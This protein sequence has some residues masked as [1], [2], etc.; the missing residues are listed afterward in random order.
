MKILIIGFGLSGKSLYNYLKNKNDEIFIYDENIELENSYNYKR[1]LNDLPLFD[2]GI[3]SPGIKK[4][5]KEYRLI[6]T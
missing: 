6:L 4:D 2:L 1:L 3:K 5:S